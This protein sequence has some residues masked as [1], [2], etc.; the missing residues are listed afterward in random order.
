MI[1]AAFTSASAHSDAAPPAPH[2]S[3]GSSPLLP[4]LLRLRIRLISVLP[5]VRGRP[6]VEPSALACAQ[7]RVLVAGGGLGGADGR[8]ANRSSA[9]NFKQMP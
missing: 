4:L 5:G 2:R 9:S 7:M 1:R 3:S 8:G 6:P